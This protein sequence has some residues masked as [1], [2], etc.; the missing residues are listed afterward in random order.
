MSDCKYLIRISTYII[1][2]S[3]TQCYATLSPILHVLHSIASTKYCNGYHIQNM[4][5]DQHTRMRGPSRCTLWHTGRARMNDAGTPTCDP[6][7]FSCLPEPLDITSFS[8]RHT[9]KYLISTPWR[10]E[11]YPGFTLVSLL[12]ALICKHSV[13]NTFKIAKS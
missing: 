4:S 7:S 3:K 11:K 9:T 8:S 5:S 10:K 13:E 2:E 6:Q 1:S 12:L